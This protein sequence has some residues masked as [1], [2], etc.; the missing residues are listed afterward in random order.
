MKSLP[1]FLLIIAF[2]LTGCKI[3]DLSQPSLLPI[4][5][6]EAKATALLDETIRAQGF[7]VMAKENVYAFTATDEWRGLLGK[8][9]KLWPENSTT[10]EFKHNFNTFDGT[11]RFMTGERKGDKIGVQSWNYYEQVPAESSPKLIDTGDKLNPL[12]F[13]TVIYHYFIEL[14]YRLRQAPIRRYYGQKEWQ[15][16]TYDLVFVSWGEEAAHPEHDQYVLYI[17]PT[18]KLVD[19]SVYTIRD[20]TSPF[21]RHKYGSIA[22]QDYQDVNGFLVPMKLPVLIDDGVVSKSSLD[23]YFHQL[24]IHEFSFGG[25]EEQ[26]LYPLPGI[27]KEIDTK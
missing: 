1:L 11:G 19:Y 2:S 6:S 10:L 5:D 23:R 20:N 12:E 7:S 27:P 22:F 17:N 21:T 16:I 26:E 4:S 15:G 8:M 24:I 25:F 3:A 13:G 18:T 14:P 9:V